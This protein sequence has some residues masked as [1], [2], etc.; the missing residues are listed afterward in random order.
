MGFSPYREAT[1]VDDLEGALRALRA[2][3]YR[4]TATRRLVLEALFQAEGPVSAEYV[5]EGM[6]GASTPMD[7]ATVHRILSQLEE[8][9][10]AHHVHIGHGPG[11]YTPVGKAHREYLAC[12]RCGRVTTVE[13]GRLDSVRRSIQK[14]FG[15]E[16]RFTHFPILGLCATCRRE[17]GATAA[18]G[19]EQ[20]EHSHEHSHGGYVHAHPHTHG[21]RGG[22]GHE[23]SH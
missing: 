22:A 6:G 5:A 21:E 11:L 16:A 15:Y 9:G 3:G 17:E 10:L 19:R 8:L 12:E 20:P 13:P 1:R 7:T 23:H 4:V 18:T 14:R 2:D